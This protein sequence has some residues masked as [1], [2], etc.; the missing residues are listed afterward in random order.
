MNI[1]PE[2]FTKNMEHLLGNECQNYFDSFD[3][4]RVYGLR[5]N[6]LKISV[7]DFL[8]INPFDLTPI[9]WTSD[10]FYYTDKDQPSKHPYYFAG[11]YYLQEPSAMLPAEVLPIEENDVVLDA[12][13]APGG[14][15]TKLACKLNN[16]G[17]LFSNDISV[18]R[19][20]ALLKNIENFGIKNSF[21][22]SNDINKLTN[23]FPNYFDKILI[24]APCSGEGMFRK[25]PSLIKSWIEKGND[26]YSPIQ[27]QILDDAVKMLKD[28]GKL[29]YSTCTFSPKEDED[30]IEYV[31]NKYPD[32]HVLP[33]KQYPG[34][35]NGLT[36]NT[37]DA[38]RLYPHKVKGEGHFVCLLQKGEKQNNKVT[39]INKANCTE[40]FINNTKM[41]FNNGKF[42]QRDTRLYFEPNVDIDL[43]GLRIMRSGLLLGE[44]KHDKFEPSIALALALKKDEY[45]NVVNFDVD[46]L[47]V[48][49][50][51]KCET[52]D[53]KDKHID[54]YVLV[55]VDNYP[56]GFGYV[57]KGILKN[58]YPAN[59][60]YQ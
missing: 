20:Q 7:K 4:P 39:T 55:C 43:N 54:G 8:A 2:L 42:I 12:C 14:K 9:P 10:G 60:R 5:I 50:Y 11:L 31:L 30:V 28:G 22:I 27:K 35:S 34:F 15:S 51:L 38:V 18:S 45:N 6:T 59:Y 1:F 58:K 24:D 3:N 25:E 37:K 46:D 16:T 19:C 26:Y 33:I 17:S 52:L 49:K 21:V 13:A 29:V 56:L 23:Y 48:Y 53:V 32:L 47:R 44:Y 41:S 57:N 40:Q 36:D